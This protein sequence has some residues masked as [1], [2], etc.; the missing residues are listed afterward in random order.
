MVSGGRA[1][2]PGGAITHESARGGF[3]ERLDGGAV[4]AVSAGAR[5]VWPGAEARA[6]GRAG[7]L[8][9]GAAS[10]ERWDHVFDPRPA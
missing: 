6:P 10:A 8:A 1:P 7:T 5:L 9:H 4:A 3:P 2:F